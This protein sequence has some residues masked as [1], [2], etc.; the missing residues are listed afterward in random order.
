MAPAG[1]FLLTLSKSCALI[2][3]LVPGTSGLLLL[4]PL[5]SGSLNHFL[6]MWLSARLGTIGGFWL[7]WPPGAFS[8][9]FW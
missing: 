6:L 2:S 7:C 8:L 3:L 1:V 5:A 9:N 4:G